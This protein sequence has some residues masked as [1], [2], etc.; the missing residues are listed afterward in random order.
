L[1]LVRH[2]SFQAAPDHLRELVQIAHKVGVWTRVTLLASFL[3]LYRRI[4]DDDPNNHDAAIGRGFLVDRF[5]RSMEA[6]G[7][8]KELVLWSQRETFPAT[9]GAPC[10]KTAH[11][12][13]NVRSKGTRFKPSTW[14][15]SGAVTSRSC[16]R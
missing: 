11:G 5:R 16:R 3:H 12:A 7:N 4:V 2:D 8:K 15:A 14:R 13:P 6:H 1:L 10:C 9:V